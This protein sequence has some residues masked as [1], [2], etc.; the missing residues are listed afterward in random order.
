MTLRV[1]STFGSYQ[2]L[3]AIGAGGMGEVYRARDTKLDRDVAIKV[4]PE[5]F[6]RNPDR[7]ARFRREARALAAINHPNIAAIYGLEESEGVHAL[8]LELVE[9][10]TLADKLAQGSG[11]KAAA[12]LPLDEVLSIA[13]QIV[14][15][16]DAAHEKGIVHR[17]LKPANVKVTPGGTVKVLDFGLA[18]TQ[19]DAADLT[20]APTEHAVVSESGVLL[21]TVPY[22]SPEQARGQAVDKR[23][24]IW[25]FGCVL[26]ELLTGRRAFHGP[27]SSDT[28]AAILERPP[29]WAAL[30]ST[31]PAAVRRLLTH[32]LEK[33]LRRRLRDIGDARLQLDEPLVDVAAV[34][35]SPGR[36]SGGDV[37]FS[38]LTDFGGMKESPAM[39][40]DG[41]MVA[42]VAFVG[43]KRQIWIRMLAGGVPLQLTRDDVDHEY[44]R[45]AP[46]S[47]TLI[48]YTPAATHGEQGTIWEIGTL[49]GWPRKVTS[50]TA[51]G[52]ISHDGQRIAVFQAV[53]DEP[54]L[55]TVA[56]DGSGAELVARVPSGDGY[57]S[58]RWSP[59]DRQI[60]FERTNY[61]GTTVF[62]DVVTLATGARRALCHGRVL[63]GFCWLADGSGVVYSSSQGST[64]FYRGCLNLR[65]IALD[66]SHDRQLT[67]GD[68][69][70]VEP[71][72]HHAGRLI[73]TRIKSPSD[74]WKIPVQG[75]PA[76]NTRGAV[77]ITAQ[78]GQVRT[79]SASPDD[80]E[81]VYLSD[82]GG[83]G[84][85][86]V[87]KT[88]GSAVRQITFERD[89][90][91]GIGLP[92][93]S[94]AGDVIVFVATRGDRIGLYLVHP[95]GS[96]LRQIVADARGLSWSGDGRWIYYESMAA[97][98]GRLE[99][100]RPEGGAP[101]VVRSEA[102]ALLPAS[103]DGT[104]L[105]YAGNLR[106]NIFGSQRSD[107]LIRCARPEGGPAE[108]LASISGDRI[109]GL[110]RFVDQVL[111]PDGQ[112][113]AIPLTDGG[114]TNIWVL[115][116]S[117]G[118]MKPVTDFGT[119]AVEIARSTSWSADGRYL[120]AAVAELE[121]DIVLLDGLI[122]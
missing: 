25:A 111:S 47:S 77:R 100:I 11:P 94:P 102:G 9:G 105:Y 22:M 23:T 55:V 87:A 106:S 39:S 41:K 35:V 4:L 115:P 71:D 8:V 70:Y 64:I 84:N 80:T 81:V 108:T 91:M 48:Y 50:A 19:T 56:R 54:A 82:N 90:S 98:T 44:P 16:L 74:V 5:A 15:A 76:E 119:R 42:F 26:F 109:A 13:R 20:N 45:W 112:W 117:G 86:W 37:A 43:G 114:T 60:A 99:K 104:A 46:D 116:T 85:L 113:L 51:G 3:A 62:V 69:S 1:G 2:I 97:E 93:W 34:S 28:I 68:Q 122:G 92:K 110:P 14:E 32:C 6:N 33:D 10:L 36:A 65:T 53:D 79:P 59:D 63:K 107:K 40:P 96:G 67:F 7:L 120:Y 57:S 31:T 75:S 29:D 118:A 21:G 121:A 88:D 38:R 95:D 89:L 52:D 12:A 101:V 72:T 17:D 30:P 24:D 18:K 73:A 83:H 27:T 61:S 49:G 66:G 103:I 58:P 78:T